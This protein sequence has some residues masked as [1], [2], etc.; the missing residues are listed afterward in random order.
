MR[1]DVAFSGGFGEGLF[2]CCDVDGVSVGVRFAMDGEVGVEG[3][4]AVSS[5]I[6]ALV[7]LLL[8]RWR[9]IRCELVGEAWAMVDWRAVL[10]ER[11]Q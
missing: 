2:P 9:I 1:G 5:A 11:V 6:L 8:Q 10:S 4:E 7:L 3:W